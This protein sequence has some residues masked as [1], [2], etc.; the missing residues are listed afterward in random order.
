MLLTSPLSSPLKNPLDVWRGI[1]GGAATLNGPRSQTLLVGDGDSITEGGGV[2]ASWLQRYANNNSGRVPNFPGNNLATGG[3]Y[4]STVIARGSTADSLLTS[5]PWAT[6]KI[7]VFAVGTNNVNPAF[8]AYYPSNA[9]GFLS[10]ALANANNRRLAGFK[11]VAVTIQPRS[12]AN[13]AGLGAYATTVAEFDAWRAEINAG[14]LAAVGSQLAA[15]INFAADPFIGLQS[16]AENPTYLSDGLHPTDALHILMEAVAAPVFNSLTVAAAQPAP[17]SAWSTTD[18][19]SALALSNAN[20]TIGPNSAP[21]YISGRGDVWRDFGKHSLQMRMTSTNEQLFGLVNGVTPT[22][23]HVGAQPPACV[24]YATGGVFSPGVTLVNAPPVP[25]LVTDV[26]V[27]HVDFDAGK[28]WVSK[29]GAFASGG[30]PET[31]VNPTWTFT[32]NT[33]FW[34]GATPVDGVATNTLPA[35]ASELLY[36]LPAGYSAW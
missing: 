4:L 24:I 3:A 9:A 16:T 35:D 36:A 34:A 28:A 15:V 8:G 21:G 26:P 19:A 29:N 14:Y 22:S 20:R 10:D 18:K 33:A 12:A 17:Y 6:S 11:T 32:P 30:N 13:L 31:G 25:F 5:I 27:F 23:T 1:Y 2:A 7:W